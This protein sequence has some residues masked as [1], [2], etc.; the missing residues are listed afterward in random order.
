MDPGGHGTGDPLTTIAGVELGDAQVPRHFAKNRH[1]VWPLAVHVLSLVTGFVIIASLDRHL[2]FF[3]DEWNFI[4]ERGL[5]HAAQGIW[6]P[7]NEHWSTLPILFWRALFSVF[8]LG[9]YWPYL[10]PLILAHLA[11]THLLW[12]AGRASGANVWIATSSAAV[13]VLFGAG[14]ENLTWAFQIT[15][16]GSLMFG[17][18]AILLGSRERSPATDG[19]VAALLV[20]SLLC[21]AVGVAMCVAAAVSFLCQRGL[22]PAV[23]VLAV[24]AAC[25]AIWYGL[26]GN[27][28]VAHDHITLSTFSGL[29][30]YVWDGLAGSLGR[31]VDLRAAGPVLLTIL[32]VWVAVS[33]GRLRR[34]SPSALGGVAGAVVFFVLT[35]LGRD[36]QSGSAT[37]SRYVYVCVALLL[38][39]VMVG[40]TRLNAVARQPARIVALCLVL[41]ILALNLGLLISYADKRTSIVQANKRQLLAI[42]TLLADGSPSLSPQPV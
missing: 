21:S 1:N 37:A 30:R 17:W 39:V 20:A 16:V 31:A 24:P 4:A 32:I 12:R 34:E 25:F 11:T 8:A 35:G 6:Q 29:P 5:N 41:L 9:S 15:F 10:V 36:G 2:W 18:A 33:F 19:A 38:P 13:F 27:D 14:A 28:G 3:G 42:G 22:R 7:H 23:R 26:A 40:A